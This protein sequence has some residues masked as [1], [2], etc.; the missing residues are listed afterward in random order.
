MELR[1]IRI[2]VIVLQESWFSNCSKKCYLRSKFWGQK[3]AP[4]MGPCR[5]HIGK[6]SYVCQCNAEEY[7][8]GLFKLVHFWGPNFDPKFWTKKLSHRSNFSAA[9]ILNMPKH[10]VSFGLYA[11]SAAM[12]KTSRLRSTKCSNFCGAPCCPIPSATMPFDL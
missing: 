6:L 5:N 11:L 9:K 8:V 10:R 1:V 3:L 2:C 7:C 4:K 12:M